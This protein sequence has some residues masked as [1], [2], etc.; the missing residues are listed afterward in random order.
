[1]Y[2]LLHSSWDQWRDQW[3]PQQSLWTLSTLVF[4]YQLFMKI[5]GSSGSPKNFRLVKLLLFYVPT[6]ELTSE[7]YCKL[8][9]IIK[10][11]A[12]LK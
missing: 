3:K 8:L 5:I 9:E 10:S 1:M 12:L 6:P 7:V 11:E 2:Q 4:I